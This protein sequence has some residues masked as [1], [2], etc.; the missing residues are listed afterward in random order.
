[1]GVAHEQQAAAG[2]ARR[3]AD[4]PAAVRQDRARRG[5]SRPH[6]QVE[7]EAHP[8]RARADL[9]PLLKDIPKRKDEPCG[10][11]TSFTA[12]K[13]RSPGWAT[14]ASDSARRPRGPRPG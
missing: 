8:G 5:E 1:M 9:L 7:K 11:R 2:Q 12:S 6:S 3:V 4:L 14:S 10:T 13:P